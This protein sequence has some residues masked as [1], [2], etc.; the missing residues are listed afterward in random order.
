MTVAGFIADQK[1]GHHVPHRV[2]CRALEVSESWFCKWR[3]RPEQPTRRE[4]GWAALA[5]R[6]THFSTP[7]AAPTVRRGSRWTCG[8]KVGRSR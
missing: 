1:T 6:I 8:L 4:A 7:R 2:A 3:R 5:E